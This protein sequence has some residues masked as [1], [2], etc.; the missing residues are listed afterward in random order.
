MRQIETHTHRNLRSDEYAA[1]EDAHFAIFERKPLQRELRTQVRHMV[2]DKSHLYT[3]KAGQVVNCNDE[4]DEKECGETGKDSKWLNI[5][6]I[7]A[8]TVVLVSICFFA[9]AICLGKCCDRNYDG[10]AISMKQGNFSEGSWKTKKGY[11]ASKKPVES[12]KSGPL[13]RMP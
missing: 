1:S 4:Y 13:K 7:V 8:A 5:V 3:N 6:V 9:K 10:N 2:D 12:D 11:K